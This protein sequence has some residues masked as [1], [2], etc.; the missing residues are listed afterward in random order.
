[1]TCRLDPACHCIEALVVLHGGSSKKRVE[2]MK[3]K[4][5]FKFNFYF[6]LEHSDLQ[7]YVSFKGTEK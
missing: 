3:E 6:L 5:F 7:F 1:M 2:G 4:S